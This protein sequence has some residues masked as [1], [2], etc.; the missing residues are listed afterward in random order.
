M[1]ERGVRF[2]AP[3]RLRSALIATVLA[4]ASMLAVASPAAASHT[5][6][7]LPI[8]FVHGGAGSGAQYASQARRFASNGYPA[9]RIR[10]LEY[11]SSS[12]AA[13]GAAPAR[14]DALIDSLRTEYGV[15]R[16]NLLG[17]SL[18]TSVSNTYLSVP[19][20]AAKIAHY[21][22][23][24]GASNA[25]CGV[26]DPDLDCMGIFR[27]S[28]GD[29]GG[30]NVYFNGTQSHVEAATSPQSFAAQYRFFTG[31][32]PKTTMI[33]P[34]P[35]GQVEVAG[36]AVNFP[37]N[38]GIDGGTVRI[39]EVNPATG[40]R[41]TAS[42]LVSIPLDATGDFGPVQV[43][44][45]QYYE[46]EVLRPDSVVALHIYYQ[47]FLRDDY[48]V[49]LLS[50]SPT[51]GISTNTLTGP[52]HAA[53]VVVRYRE[54]WTTHPSGN[55]D[56]LL[57]STR[58]PSR[59]DEPP[60][61]ALTNVISSGTIGSPIGVHVHDNPT[62]QVSSLNLIPFF[63]TQAFQTGVDVYMPATTPADGT[64]TFRNDPR[65]D[66]SRPQV[67]NTPN[68]ASDTNRISVYLNDYVQDVNSWG[69]CKK[70]KPSP[71]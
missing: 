15:D 69:E 67:L 52:N 71:C 6:P 17:H 42:P 46:F 30:N 60:V 65:G 66:T 50:S 40:A 53:A 14:L 49:R 25:N 3:R 23:I 68:W 58:S 7:D 70:L 38:A 31:E 24:D 32:D 48:L 34:E 10:T 4:A 33:L 29:V 41:K 9:D 26:G 56:D 37:Q 39:W 63:T 57:I 1:E 28:T 20:R 13:I 44:G 18:G 54:W 35:P 19:A 5:A 64:I 16:V 36:R 8:V 45:Q 27:G 47:P 22:G 59:G 62:D 61:N 43:N 2:R 51:S 21:V 55:E 12:I 11:D